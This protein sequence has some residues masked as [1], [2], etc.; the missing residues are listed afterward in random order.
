[1]IWGYP[2]FRK[3]PYNYIGITVAIIR[4]LSFFVHHSGSTMNGDDRFP[5]TCQGH[6]LGTLTHIQWIG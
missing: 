2:S 6:R 5:E 1:M 4:L 3:P